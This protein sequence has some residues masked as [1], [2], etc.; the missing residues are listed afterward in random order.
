[1]TWSL[2]NMYKT[3]VWIYCA[4]DFEWFLAQVKKNMSKEI[5]VCI[6]IY[7]VLFRLVSSGLLHTA[8]SPEQSKKF[9]TRNVYLLHAV[10]KVVN[11]KRCIL[12]QMRHLYYS[13]SFTLYSIIT[14][15]AKHLETT[16]TNKLNANRNIIFIACA[17]PFQ[18]MYIHT[19]SRDMW[20]RSLSSENVQVILTHWCPNKITDILHIFKLLYFDSN[21][22]LV[23][24]QKSNLPYVQLKI[25]HFNT[26]VVPEQNY[27]HFAH[28]Q[29][30]VFGFKFHWILFP[31]VQLTI[32]HY[33]FR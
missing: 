6:V 25:C 28:I 18:Y 22:T 24:S 19:L 13:F 11:C 10:K 21:F 31:D 27:S 16:T 12:M 20:Q 1:M 8:R 26:L 33:C 32:H 23:C 29:I 4:Y 2:V 15:L 9:N 7:C 3:H 5:N 14:T 17:W 30:L